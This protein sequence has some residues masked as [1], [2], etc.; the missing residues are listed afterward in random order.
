M[1]CFL[2]ESESGVVAEIGMPLS[3]LDRLLSKRIKDLDGATFRVIRI[4]TEAGQRF[5]VELRYFGQKARLTQESDLSRF[6]VRFG[7]WV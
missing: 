6:L 7:R 5:I 2:S 3:E 4:V 1:R